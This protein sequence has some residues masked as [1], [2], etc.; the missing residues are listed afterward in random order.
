MVLQQ[1]FSPESSLYFR[2]ISLCQYVKSSCALPTFLL[3][4]SAAKQ[5]KWRAN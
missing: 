4:E 1:L 3:E 2:Q 5:L